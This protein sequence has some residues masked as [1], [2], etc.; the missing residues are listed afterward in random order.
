MLYSTAR[1]LAIQANR[2][3]SEF[4]PLAENIELRPEDYTVFFNKLREMR[5]NK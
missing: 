1:W 3:L 4:L 5:G 2:P